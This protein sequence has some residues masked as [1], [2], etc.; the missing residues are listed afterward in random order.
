MEA[1]TRRASTR[2]GVSAVVMIH[3]TE[4]LDAAVYDTDGNYVGRVR[5]LCIDPNEQSNRIARLVIARG[6]FQSLLVRYDQVA[7]VA[8]NTV[9]LNAAEQALEPYTPNEAWLTVRK[10]LLDQQIIDIHG[11]KVVRVND[12]D[13]QEF[14]ADGYME[15][16]VAQVDVG[17]AGALR[18]LLK[19]VLSPGWI[20]RLQ[21]KLPARLI[22]WE[23]VDMIETDPLRRVKLKISHA[24]L[25]RLHPADIADILEELAPA[26][27]EA[28][29]E[30]LDEATAAET[31]GELKPELQVRLVE[32]LDAERAA[33]I[34]E[35]MPADERA[36]LLAELPDKTSRELLQDMER[37]QAAETEALLQFGEHTAG[38]LM[39]PQVFRA[40]DTSQV[41]AV[42]KSLREA[43]GELD[44]LDTIYLVNAA[45]VLTGAVPV[46]RLLLAPP[47]T[48]LLTLCTDQLVFVD[49]EGKEP[50]VIELFDKYNLRSLPVVDAEQKLVGVI[51]ADDVI[52]R[53]WHAH[54]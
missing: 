28:V 39:N 45:G 20:R 27:R 49:T 5:E 31:L 22:P 19:G 7:S 15:L 54:K 29:I 8:P 1:A 9:R 46:P 21:K 47:E 30:T 38:G 23:F 13:L 43:T 33:G 16:R 18:R 24:K 36:D 12:L 50:Q 10:D 37:E 6:R 2:N 48:S 3:V 44:Q 35:H 14:P 42:V 11:R 51:T 40:A 26:E 34:L 17:L 41:G 4:L 53:L 32:E 25:A 52:S